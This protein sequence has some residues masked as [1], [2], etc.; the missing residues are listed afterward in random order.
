MRCRGQGLDLGHGRPTFSD[1]GASE[2]DAAGSDVHDG[3]EAGDGV[4]GESEPHERGDG[5]GF[6]T[7]LL[8]VVGAVGD[9]V[10]LDVVL[11]AVRF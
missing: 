11:Q 3:E 9:A 8:L 6:P 4:G 7:A 5:L 10:V 2:V 1:A